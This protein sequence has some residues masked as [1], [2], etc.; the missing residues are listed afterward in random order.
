MGL[1]DGYPQGIGSYV[2][3]SSGA[4]GAGA[5]SFILSGSS[6]GK[7]ILVT[8]T[9]TPGTLI[10]TATSVNT[11]RDILHLWFSNIHTADVDLT[12]EWG[13]VTDPTHLLMK[14]VS[15]PAKSPPTQFVFGFPIQMGLAIRGF[16]SVASKIQ[17]IGYLERRGA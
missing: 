10:H 13:G 17:I 1:R 12:I 14:A 2:G 9:A 15:I 7:P 6:Y 5:P 8:A 11:L 4:P 3:G 16:A